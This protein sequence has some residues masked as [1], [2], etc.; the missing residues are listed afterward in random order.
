MKA[1]LGKRLLA[2]FLILAVLCT[3]F[4]L[5]MPVA[6]LNAGEK[7]AVV[8]IPI[9]DRPFHEERMQLM[10]ESLDIELIMPEE[11]LYAT[12]LTGQATN[13]NGTTY[14]D[15]GALL[16]WL[17]EQAPKYDTFILSMD[18][19]LSG[20]LMHS[21]CMTDMSEICLPDGTS[22]TEYQVIDYL[23]QLAETKTVYVLD[24]E[25]RLAVSCDYDGYDLNDYDITRKYGLV[26]RPILTG[27]A[28]TLENILAS[29]QLSADGGAAYLDA[30]LSEA[31]LKVLMSPIGASDTLAVTS[32]MIEAYT[33]GQ[34]LPYQ[35][36]NVLLASQVPQEAENSL[37]ATYL[38]I[39][40]R[41]LRLVEYGLK[42][43]CSMENVHYL[44]GVDDSSAGNNIQTNEIALLSQYLGK[45]GQI[46]S[47]VD[48]LAQAALEQIYANAL[49]AEP[50]RVSAQYFGDQAAAVGTYN[51]LEHQEA[52]EKTLDYQNGVL[53]DQQPEVSLLVLTDSDTEDRRNA[54]LYQLI[55]QLNEN[56]ARQ[57]PTILLDLSTTEKSTTLTLLAENVHMGMLLSYSASDENPVQ[58]VMAI[59]QGL[60]RYMSL[61]SG[62]SLSREAQESHLCNL[63]SSLVK[64][65]YRACGGAREMLRYLTAQ[66]YFS[67]LGQPGKEAL[68]KIQEVLNTQVTASAEV[69]T[70]SFTSSNFISSLQPYTLGGITEA[71]VVSSG[72]PW[73]RTFEIGCEVSC[74][75][76][77]TP[78]E[79]GEFHGSYVSG[80]TGTSFSGTQPLTRSQAA[81]LLI[82][83]SGREDQENETCPFQDVP[84]WAK[85]YV[86]AA[87]QLGYL[88]GYSETVFRGDQNM[89]RAEF[90]A[91]LVQYLEA[92]GLTLE[93]T[94]SPAFTDVS[95]DSG[96]WYADAVYTLADAGVIHGY[97]DGTFQPNGKITRAEAVQLLS[98][99]FGRDETLPESL[100][101]V[102]RFSDVKSSAWF[103]G[104]VQE[105]SIS[106]FCGLKQ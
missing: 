91:M 48:G 95:R 49:Q 96:A 100:G 29:Y 13:Q 31:Q 69:L 11:D 98:R 43:L 65:Y 86:A 78:Y 60:A 8:Y 70:E 30:G 61:T 73:L 27:T 59:S 97:E 58:V 76:G 72:F 50:V 2:A 12:K 19:L 10:A 14:G 57:L 26:D 82:T 99:F 20:G 25:F 33:M 7:L 35:A 22:M 90:A 46:Y 6:A 37:L 42:T 34:E 5:T 21:R 15:R 51:Y 93:K 36:E 66:G 74:A 9:D 38:K 80:I 28:L 83:V 62:K 81:K 64:E 47:A 84:S 105:A 56:E 32:E 54:A 68:E 67:N 41:K 106:H 104:A 53:V 55:S 44:L 85:P 87:Y 101:Q 4:P 63:Y 75:Y 45:Q 102:C 77:E 92:E 24:S 18:Q 1:S 3:A 79:L 17:M 16:A 23:R 103:Y 52:I 39:R 94:A 40:E 88:Q 89:T 71:K